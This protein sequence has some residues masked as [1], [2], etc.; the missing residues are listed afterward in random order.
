MLRPEDAKSVIL[1]DRRRL[2]YF[3]VGHPDGKPIMFFH[4]TPNTAISVDETPPE[5]GAR[6]I[7]VNR[8]GYGE[9]D[10]KPYRTLLE[11]ADDVRELADHLDLGRFAVCGVSGGGP[12]VLVCAHELVD[13]LAC[14]AVVSS[15]GSPAYPV[16]DERVNKNTQETV[17][18]IRE[19]PA[20][21]YESL[22][23]TVEK[24]MAN[25]GADLQAVL[26]SM[27]EAERALFAS[28]LDVLP[29][30]I[31]EAYTHGADGWFGDQMAS[32][33]NPWGFNLEDIRTPV[34]LYHG[35]ADS[36]VS[37]EVTREYERR[38]PGCRARYYPGEGHWA[39]RVHWL[40]I[41]R[42]VMNTG[43]WQ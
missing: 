15:I 27:P 4:G 8:P 23:A 2:S 21:Y 13:R 33:G 39:G 12:H 42:D 11:W 22:T 3:E 18:T 6:V 38:I 9:S 10:P 26:A 35:D 20:R 25:P 19:S 41:L 14:A 36:N 16:A 37:V 32:R 1:S 29:V 17:S 5:T 28:K 40:E 24:R 34:L 30:W 31:N 7:S 43:E